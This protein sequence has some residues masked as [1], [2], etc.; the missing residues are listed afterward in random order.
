MIIVKNYDKPSL[1]GFIDKYPAYTAMFSPVT[2]ELRLRGK[3]PDNNEV[4]NSIEEFDEY[5]KNRKDGE[6]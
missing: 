5:V 4:F 1:V 6:E 2:K 3:K